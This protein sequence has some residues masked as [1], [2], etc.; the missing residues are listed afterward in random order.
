[1]SERLG[2]GE[3]L[4][5]PPA[6][7]TASSVIGR[8][9]RWLR[10]HRQLDFAD[11]H[12]LWAWS[13]TDLEGFWS[14]VGEFF[15]VRFHSP[16]RS[17]LSGAMPEARWFEG[18]TLNYAEHALAQRSS[19]VA[20]I[21]ESQTVGTREFTW[22]ELGELVGRARA[23]LSRAGIEPGDRVAAYLPNIPETVVAFLATASLGAIWSSCS[24]E[25]GVR[26]V[27]DR[28]AQIEPKVLLVIDGY[29]YGSRVI[30]L[31]ENVAAIRAGLPSVQE[32]VL[33]PVLD[34]EAR[35][36][37]ARPWTAWLADP[38]ALEF[39]PVPFSHPLYI[40]FTS[41]TTGLPKPIIH[42]HGG[43]VIEHLKALALQSDIGPGDRFF[44]FTTT[45][46]MMWNFLVS[47]LLVGAT[48]V[49]FDGDPAHPDL[50]TLW[51]LAARQ[52]ITWMGLSAAFLMACRAGGVH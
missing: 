31:R 23:A 24:P 20:L 48:V 41:G 34:P 35:I 12:Q 47:G 5:S 40:L 37:G 26:A 16:P 29:R 27:V 50:T 7:V 52:G 25:F 36:A 13:V 18:A 19:G 49:L 44:W 8:Y 39:E 9:L 21:G 51:R 15:G 10:V 46:W 6:D 17:I 28:F 3:V 45:G 42:G 38:G 22:P 2:D 30:D 33:V 32:T 1:M 14:S 11:Y 43:I 4:W